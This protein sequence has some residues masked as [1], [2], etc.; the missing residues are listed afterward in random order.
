MTGFLIAGKVIQSLDSIK[1]ELKEL[2]F[3]FNCISGQFTTFDRYVV[4]SNMSREELL[5]KY[6]NTVKTDID[7]MRESLAKT[8]K[9]LD[10]LE[11]IIDTE[12]NEDNI[13]KE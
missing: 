9:L 4:N 12:Y 3:K 5:S 6:H 11:S 2:K 13:N 1:R 10:T 7:G 8:Q